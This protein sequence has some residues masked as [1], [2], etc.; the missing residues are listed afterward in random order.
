[1]TNDLLGTL[2]DGP[3]LVA[4]RRYWR[5]LPNTFIGALMGGA[6]IGAYLV[7]VLTITNMLSL[8]RV[9]VGWPLIPIA[10]AVQ[11]TLYLVKKHW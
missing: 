6:L 8:W 4:M 3:T 9:D 10:I 7:V 5:P 11:G 1:M 2:A